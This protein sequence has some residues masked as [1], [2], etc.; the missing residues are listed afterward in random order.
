MQRAGEAGALGGELHVIVD[1]GGDDLGGNATGR[2]QLAR[3]CD[4]HPRQDGHDDGGD[5]EH[6]CHGVHRRQQARR[7][8][9]NVTDSSVV[10]AGRDHQPVAGIDLG[11]IEQIGV[12][13][14]PLT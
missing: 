14:A 1:L 13:P 7:G 3:L 8:S 9:T 10:P 4:H 6:G 11:A 2:I 5:E 12:A